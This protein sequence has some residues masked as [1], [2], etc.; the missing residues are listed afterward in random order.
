MSDCCDARIDARNVALGSACP[1]CSTKGQPVEALAIKAL[2]RDTALGR[3]GRGPYL[4]CAA[5]NCD[6]VYFGAGGQTFLATD[7]RVEVWQKVPF[8]RRTVCYCFGENEAAMR[9]ESARTGGCAAVG[10]VR[11]QIAAGRCACEVRNPR[12]VCCLGDLTEAVKRV[13]ASARS[14]AVSPPVNATR[15]QEEDSR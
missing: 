2:L 12:G 10:R 1:T 3:I 4:F 15:M 6:V 5:A 8:G 9:D 14:T 11:A 13:I 7:V